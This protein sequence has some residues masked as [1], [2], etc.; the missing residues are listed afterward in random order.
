MMRVR[1]V[2]EWWP[3]LVQAVGIISASVIIAFMVWVW[4]EGW[5]V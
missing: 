1:V 5:W 2:I 3:L 4:M